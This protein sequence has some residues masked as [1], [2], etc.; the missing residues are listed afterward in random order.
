[1]KLNLRQICR[2][3]RGSERGG[4]LI[5]ILLAL[6]LSG[7]VVAAG[8]SFIAVQHNSFLAQ[9]NIVDTQQNVRAA[10][11]EMT[12]HFRRA[13]SGLPREI[14][15]VVGRNTNPD[16]VIVRYSAL[17]GQLYVGDPT[18]NKQAVPIH[19]LVGSD[20]SPFAVGQKVYLIHASNGQ[21][22]WFTITALKDNAGMGWKEVHHQGQDLLYNPDLGDQI[23][24]MSEFRYFVDKSTDTAHPCLM[25]Q[26]GADA[27]QIFADYIEDLQC[28]YF[29]PNGDSTTTPALGDTLLSARVTVR[30][31]THSKDM[32]WEDA[33]HEAKRRRTITAEVAVRNNLQ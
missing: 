4:G 23:I 5:E 13:G 10:I 17:G 25:R 16:T 2:P 1:M 30:G 22:E 18:S 32:V 14:Q 3:I 29:K 24:A 6:F 12:S 26:E 11:D 7:I 15:Y 8:L 19:V 21:G 20:L 27:P 28:M 33:G 9:D 31:H